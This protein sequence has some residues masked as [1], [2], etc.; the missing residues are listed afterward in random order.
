MFAF[1]KLE[2]MVIQRV[3]DKVVAIR[4]KFNYTVDLGCGEGKYWLKKYTKYLVGVD[5]RWKDLIVAKHYHGYNEVFTMDMRNF[6]IPAQCDSVL[7]IQSIEHIPKEDG[8]KLIKSFGN[9]FILIT[10]PSKFFPIARNGHVS[11]W[12]VNDFQQLGF[13]VA[14]FGGDSRY[15][16]TIIAVRWLKWRWLKWM[17]R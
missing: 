1:A 2:D 11:L 13:E 9:R 10:T 12:T 14:T 6:Q 4:G 17:K 5:H 15:G 7:M 8:L 16:K 3:L